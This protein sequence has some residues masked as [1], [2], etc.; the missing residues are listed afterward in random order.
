MFGKKINDLKT[1]LFHKRIANRQREVYNN[2]RINSEL[3]KNALLIEI[4]FK[5]KIIIGHGPR[6]LNTEYYVQKQKSLLGINNF[7]KYFFF[8]LECIKYVIKF[9]RF[10]NILYKE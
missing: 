4:D 9:Q 10:W 3:L 1:I 7:K 2:S 6:Q 5:Q 8:I